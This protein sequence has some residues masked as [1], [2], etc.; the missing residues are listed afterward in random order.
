[1]ERISTLEWVSGMDLKPSK[2]D[3]NTNNSFSNNTCSFN[4]YSQS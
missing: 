2:R 4:I 1:M 3:Y